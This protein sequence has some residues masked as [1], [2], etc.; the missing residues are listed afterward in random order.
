MLLMKAGCASQDAK[1]LLKESGSGHVLLV[2]ILHKARGVRITKSP[3]TRGRL[4]NLAKLIPNDGEPQEERLPKNS[5][6]QQNGSKS[7]RTSDTVRTETVLMFAPKRWGPSRTE[8]PYGGSL[9]PW[10]PMSIRPHP[11]RG[12]DRPTPTRSEPFVRT[13]RTTRIATASV[14]CGACS[15]T[16]RSAFGSSWT[17]PTQYSR[18]WYMAL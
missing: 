17:R 2:W 15:R 3:T 12:I 8:P 6:I 14:P 18:K 9:D 13:G 11:W 4:Q 16:C 10:R 5:H 1:A 7:Y